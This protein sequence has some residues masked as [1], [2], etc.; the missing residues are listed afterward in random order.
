[1]SRRSSLPLTKLERVTEPY[2]ALISS[3]LGDL[4]SSLWMDTADLFP[5]F[6]EQFLEVK[7]DAVFG[8]RSIIDR[9][10]TVTTSFTSLDLDISRILMESL[11]LCTDLAIIL[12]RRS[13]AL[14]EL[15]ARVIG[16]SI[17]MR[18]FQQG[19]DAS[20]VLEEI[21]NATGEPKTARKLKQFSSADFL[22]KLK[23]DLVV[24]SCPLENGM[25]D[26]LWAIENDI[27]EPIDV[28]TFLGS[29]G[30]DAC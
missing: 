1:M 3:K 4:S 8:L 17:I 28:I 29:G 19:L 18:S 10:A 11:H 30:G 2:I 14:S 21:A 20:K 27:L 6:D 5:V 24:A 9:N 7:F 16:M 23:Q 15:F 22:T 13:L 25:L 12:P 26:G